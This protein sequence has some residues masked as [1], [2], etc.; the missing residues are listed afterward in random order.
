MKVFFQ[1]SYR[2]REKYVS[3]YKLIYDE[4]KRLGYS[5]CSDEVINMTT[6]Q[7]YENVQGGRDTQ[8]AFYQKNIKKIQEADINIFETSN[9][10]LGIGFLIQKSLDY[11]K[12]T[13]V[14]HLE[15]SPAYFLLG[16][17]DEK[18]IVRAYNKKNLKKIVHDT[19]ELARERRDKRFNFFLSPKLL[20]Y[21]EEASK[22]DGVT[23]SK[24]IRDLIVEHM[25]KNN[26]ELV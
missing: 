23:K 10:S 21:L 3:Y 16:A 12:P 2:E 19:L 7:F 17:Q 26:A 20:D 24:L 1:A 9:H 5:H 15:D 25:R 11:A 8:L 22:K 14:L 13:I 6:E 18:L 4:I